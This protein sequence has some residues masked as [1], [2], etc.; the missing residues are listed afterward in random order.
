MPR[1]RLLLALLL[2]LTL[3]ACADDLPPARPTATPKPAST[4][5]L[6]TP[7]P[8]MPAPAMPAPATPAPATPAAATP[9]PAAAGADTWLVMLYSDA[10]DATLEEDMITDLNE[11]E[12]AGGSANVTIVAQVDRYRGAYRGDGN[13]TGTRRLRITPDKDLKTL[14]SEV[15]AEL[16]EQN[17]ADGQTLSDF[18]TWAVKTYP[19]KRHALIMSD[20]GMGWPGG[21]SDGSVDDPGPDGLSLTSD[22]DM[23]LL[24]EI[25]DALGRS[26]KATGMQSL[27]LLGFDACL[28]GQVEVLTAM[29]PHT[30]V[31]VASEEV[32]PTLGWAYGSF[33]SQ[34]VKQP[35]MDGRALGAA[36]VSSYIDQDQRILDPKERADLVKETFGE[37]RAGSAR[38]VAADMGVDVTLAAYDVA[39][40]PALLD[41][42][43]RF[44]SALAGINKKTVSSA[45]T[46]AQRF[47][48]ALDDGPSPYIDL[49]SFAALVKKKTTNQEADAA[50]DALVKALGRTVY[51]ERHGGE[52]SGARGLAIYFPTSKLYH[53]RDAGRKVYAKVAARFAQQSDWE[54]FL[55][56]HYYGVAMG[57]AAP[58]T[59]TLAAPGASELSVA[60]LA[61]S[62]ERIGQGDTVTVSTSVAG[63]QIG[64][65][66]IFTGLYDAES[67]SILVADI[68]YL[69]A[70]ETRDEGGVFYP[71]WGEDRPVELEYDWEPVRYGIGDGQTTIFALF[72]PQDYGAADASA[73]YVVR[74]TYTFADGETRRAELSFKDGALIKVLGF[75]VQGQLSAPRAITP[76]AG[77]RFTVEHQRILVHSDSAAPVE[78]VTEP[79]GAI[80]FGAGPVTME[81]MAAPAGDYVLGVQ[82]EDMDGNRYESY[83]SVTV[84]E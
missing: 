15:V 45:R 42:L 11:A 26:R 17:M 43:D 19:A 9:K 41:A 54:N 83:A 58:N 78:Y 70:G 51:A 76:R 55:D 35:S 18:V 52:R 50:A 56:Y 80:T 84:D 62:A 6:H 21:W 60:D 74:G 29:A 38:S 48:N 16:G 34:L 81:T 47:E 72:E 39:T 22:G 79:G 20:H 77:D 40:L 36:I 32:E 68:D 14:D 82:A 25:D 46:Y 75:N 30:R 4:G 66:Y 65:V 1:R 63:D 53:S 31:V 37:S 59:L 12:L 5:V 24:S 49:A 28:M 3:A 71:E 44:S 67:D 2:L 8:A 23:L 61:L 10:D 7:A 13:W 64:F 27:D 57:E 69:D 73:T 33:L